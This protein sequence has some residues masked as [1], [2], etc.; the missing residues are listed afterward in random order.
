MPA[1]QSVKV[2]QTMFCLISLDAMA[3]VMACVARFV[4][5][6]VS[7][8]PLLACPFGRSGQ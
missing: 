7:G 1:G 8:L 6:S 3:T 2:T 4:Q 5:I